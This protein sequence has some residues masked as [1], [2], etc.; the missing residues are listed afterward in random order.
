MVKSGM[1]PVGLSESI[2]QQR[3]VNSLISLSP[4][5]VIVEYLSV[6]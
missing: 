2:T 5:L 1:D 4:S 3:G 6:N